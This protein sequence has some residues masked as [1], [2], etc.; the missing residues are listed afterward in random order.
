MTI[1]PIEKLVLLVQNYW[2]NSLIFLRVCNNS[3]IINY[4]LYSTS[5]V[6]KCY[7]IYRYM[8]V[9]VISHLI[10]DSNQL[11]NDI[12]CGV[13]CWF[14]MPHTSL[15]MWYRGNLFMMSFK[16]W[17]IYFRIWKTSRRNVSSVKCI[18]WQFGR[19]ITI[20]RFKWQMQLDKTYHVF[21]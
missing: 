10:Q 5:P 20:I 14:V 9:Y 17:S 16:F 4:Q 7:L 12:Q 6:E 8:F 18:Y 13:A 1:C 21:L 2:T 11:D 3:T 15:F 19:W